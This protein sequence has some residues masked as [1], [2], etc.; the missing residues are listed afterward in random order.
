M[1]VCADYK[2]GTASFSQSAVSIT[3]RRDRIVLVWQG[4]V[5]VNGMQP[6]TFNGSPRF[7]L[8]C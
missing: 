4:L 1:I 2:A 3:S 8:D 6:E 7:P 5:A